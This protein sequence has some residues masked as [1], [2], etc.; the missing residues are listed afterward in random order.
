MKSLAIVLVGVYAYLRGN[1][2]TDELDT[3]FLLGNNEIDEVLKKI[4][5]VENTFFGDFQKSCEE[6]V[7]KYQQEAADLKE[8]MTEAEVELDSLA[9]LDDLQGELAATEVE[10]DNFSKE[11]QDIQ[12]S[13]IKSD[14][15]SAE[16]LKSHEETISELSQAADSLKRIVNSDPAHIQEALT[17]ITLLKSTL[18]ASSPSNP[19]ASPSL[20]LISS[21]ISDLSS[22]KSQLEFQIEAL[23]SEKSRLEVYISTLKPQLA[24]IYSVTSAKE[25]KCKY[26]TSLLNDIKSLTISSF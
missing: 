26:N 6:F 14:L 9:R 3:V 21:I 8:I 13:S 23:T 1:Q 20:P 12:Q 7:N 10:L 15:K 11:M 25:K 19:P 17:H 22:K 18:Q 5:T 2:G 24:A 4:V 16:F